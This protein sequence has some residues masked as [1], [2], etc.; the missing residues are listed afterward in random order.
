[1]IR[2]VEHFKHL[3]KCILSQL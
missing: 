3:K 2:L 1:M